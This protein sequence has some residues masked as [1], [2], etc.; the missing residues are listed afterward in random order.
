MPPRW[1]YVDHTCLLD[2]FV[3]GSI[4]SSTGGADK[5]ARNRGRQIKFVSHLV[6]LLLH[7]VR[8]VRSQPQ[9]LARQQ[10]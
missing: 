4:A 6:L 1:P 3:E 5:S 10:A 8:T 9:C 7:S 2:V